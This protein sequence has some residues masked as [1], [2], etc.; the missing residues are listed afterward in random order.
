MQLAPYI[1]QWASYAVYY[2]HRNEYID[3]P[4]TYKFME[5]QIWAFNKH[6]F[7]KCFNPQTTYS[8]VEPLYL[9]Y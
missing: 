2:Y 1:F 4:L 3:S 6:Q 5:N 9:Q 8:Q 7:F